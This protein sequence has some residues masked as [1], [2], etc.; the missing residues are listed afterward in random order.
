MRKGAKFRP[1]LVGDAG[2][3]RPTLP[4]RLLSIHKD[5]AL[6]H[7]PQPPTTGKVLLNM[8]PPT[9]RGALIVDETATPLPQGEDE[10]GLPT[11]QPWLTNRC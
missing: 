8:M 10:G 11:C 4:D 5:K 9:P 1:A 3:H 2:L 6:G 7:T